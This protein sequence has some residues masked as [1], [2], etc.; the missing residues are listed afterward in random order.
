MKRFALSALI[1]WKNKP[2]R[3][4]L[5]IQG[6]RQ[7]GKTELV[8]I[9]ARQEFE[10]FI[11]I[12]F[13]EHPKQVSLFDDEDIH[14]VL[15]FIEIDT[16]QRIIPGKTLLFLDEIQSAPS[17]LAKLRYFY[18]R[19]PE[20]HVICAGSLLDFVLA[21]PEY[22]MPVGRIEFLYLG[23]M[24]FDEFLLA[25]GQDQLYEYVE[26]YPRS[27]ITMG[28]DHAKVGAGYTG[29]SVE[30]GQHSA[31]ASNL[32][33]PDS[34]PA[35]F[36]ALQF[37][38]IPQVIH[39]KL[40]GF[41]REYFLVGGLPGVVKAYV[42]S[43]LDPLAAGQ[44]QQ[45]IL[46]TYYLDF[47]KYRKRVNVSLLQDLLKR[48][49]SQVGKTVKYSALDPL[50]RSA[51]VKDSL[52]LL[53]KARLI[54]RVFHS[55]GNGLPLGAEVNRSYFKL[56]FLDTG[57]FSAFLGLKLSDFLANVDF[58]L[59]H[60]GSVAEQFIGQQLLYANDPWAEPSLFYWNRPNKSSTAEVDYLI[61]CAGRVVPIEV[62]AG[63]TGRL[64]SLQMFVHEKGAPIALRFN[65][66][67]PSVFVTHTSVAGKEPVPFVLLS[68]PLYMAQ[69]A[70]QILSGILNLV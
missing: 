40:L 31:D 20:L 3:K 14:N 47:G 62:K 2:N 69:Q 28:V 59:V 58:T 6:A 15:R 22:S 67:L 29:D 34:S 55:D 48:I 49:P 25:R 24:S 56:L 30:Y 35:D 45:S 11:E 9:F 61:S 19:L 46:Q 10:S 36:R 33:A 17:I 60:S 53:E 37:M 63:T 8:R 39:S 41:L 5:V 66:G 16:N 54:Y 26:S 64:K 18:E 43:G 27:G 32:S 57:L 68:L 65:S 50:V 52:D 38:S 1:E 4:P 42:E 23:P 44:E 13:D 12:N 21:E 51:A 70:P 7:V